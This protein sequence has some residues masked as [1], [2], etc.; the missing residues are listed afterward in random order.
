M[1]V[2]HSVSCATRVRPDAS[3]LKALVKNGVLANIGEPELQNVCR[4]AI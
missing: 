4:A 1:M 3:W 2:M